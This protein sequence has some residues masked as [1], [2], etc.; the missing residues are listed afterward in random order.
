MSP[1]LAMTASAS[2]AMAR[3]SYSRVPTGMPP[4]IDP[5]MAASPALVTRG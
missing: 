3:V 4:T 1:T 5:A 2:P